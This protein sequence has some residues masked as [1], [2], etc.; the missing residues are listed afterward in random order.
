MV[1]M[2]G[3]SGVV[4]GWHVHAG[5]HGGEGARDVISEGPAGDISVLY[6]WL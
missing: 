1:G 3:H 2:E 5:H 6:L 4:G